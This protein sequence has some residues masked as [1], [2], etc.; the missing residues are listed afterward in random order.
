MRTNQS[1]AEDTKDPKYFQDI[2]EQARKVLGSDFVDNLLSILGLGFLTTGTAIPLMLLSGQQSFKNGLAKGLLGNELIHLILKLGIVGVA[3]HYIGLPVLLTIIIRLVN[4]FKDSKGQ[5]GGSYFDIEQAG[6]DLFYHFITHPDNGDV[7]S[8]YSKE[9]R[10]IINKYMN[11]VQSGGKKSGCS[12]CKS[13]NKVKFTTPKNN[14]ITT[15]D[16]NNNVY[17]FIDDNYA[18]APIEQTGG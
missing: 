8:T 7:Y 9:G 13:F 6:G 10:E 18:F 2:T 12:Q 17:D 1:M 15:E 11:V 3:P 14:N 4:Q 16:Q 5:K